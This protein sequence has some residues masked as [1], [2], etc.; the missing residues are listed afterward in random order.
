MNHFSV[1]DTVEYVPAMQAEGSNNRYIGVIQH[2][3][4]PDAHHTILSA[5][6]ACE[7]RITKAQTN[8]RSYMYPYKRGD[9]MI[10]HKSRLRRISTSPT[11]LNRTRKTVMQKELKALPP[12]FPF[13]GGENYHAI[14][15]AGNTTA[16]LRRARNNA[17]TLR[18]YRNNTRKAKWNSIVR[19]LPKQPPGGFVFEGGKR[20][21]V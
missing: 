2:C 1:G 5:P 10:L 17:K 11:S 9:T 16:P 3:W 12:M 8:P 21:R 19:S 18:K 13:P 4:G 15:R 20:R 7:I 14:G 6:D